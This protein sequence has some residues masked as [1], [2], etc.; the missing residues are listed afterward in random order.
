MSGELDADQ[1]TPPAAPVPAAALPPENLVRGLLL[2]L[3]IIP[4]GVIVF[5]LLW[6]LGFISAIVGFGV[7][8]GAFFLF[9][10][11]SGGRVSIPGAVV[12]T[13][14]TVVTLVLAFLIAIA[15][16]VAHITHVSIPEAL[17]GPNLGRAIGANGLNALITVGFG[18]LGCFTV[19]RNAFREARTQA[20]PPTLPPPAA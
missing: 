11:G 10:L 6:N 19:L 18:L 9:R 17:F 2:T 13:V 4:A 14:V 5:V 3:V 7:A 1:P 8:F 15:S 16:D 20:A 12:I